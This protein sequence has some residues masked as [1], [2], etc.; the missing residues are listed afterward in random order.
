[1]DVGRTE[2]LIISYDYGSQSVFALKEAARDLC[3]IIWLV[4]LSTPEM[5]QM[6]RL[7]DRVG[8]VV[9]IAGLSQGQV[10]QSLSATLPTGLLTLSDSA[11]VPLAEIARSLGLEFHSP[12]VARCLSDK[13]LQRQA[14]QVAGLPTPDFREIPAELDS[15]DVDWF[16]HEV[17]F[18]AVLKPRQGSG[19]R[20]TYMVSNRAELTR[21]M[22]DPGPRQQEWAGMILEQ[23]MPRTQESVSRFEPIVSV[24]SFVRGGSVHHFAVTGRLPFAE[25]FRET[26]LV[27]PSDLSPENTEIAE[28][29]ATAA[30]SALGVRHG[31]VHTELKFT[32]E[33]PRIIEVN[34]RIGGGIPQLVK[35]AAGNTSILRIIMELALGVPDSIKVP[36]RYS[37]IGW[38]LTAP[39]PVSADRIDTI[40]GLDRLN[41]VSGIDQIIINRMAGEAIDWRRGLRDYV[42]QV[43]GSAGDY[44]EV[45]AQCAMVDRAVTVTYDER[46]AIHR[47]HRMVGF[48]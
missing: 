36:L 13:L 2:R 39:P 17:G 25:P 7:M 15:V 41:N 12:E 44:D 34:G 46:A 35:L 8:I 24:E 42:Y 33:G 19:S 9:D 38:Q 20:N 1:M 31:C 30:I 14:L 4:D 37:R 3:E 18:P 23:Y 48:P 10:V 28:K 27:L 22:A 26:G 29:Q 16:A 21:L 5:A 47:N 40:A 45:E 11:M 32:P 43:Y 6:A